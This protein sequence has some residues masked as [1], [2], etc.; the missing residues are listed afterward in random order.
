M[1]Y[2]PALTVVT[3]YSGKSIGGCV[4][5]AQNMERARTYSTELVLHMF[6]TVGILQSIIY[7]FRPRDFILRTYR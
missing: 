3:V 1:R 4:S 6:R 5:S 7:N 2:V